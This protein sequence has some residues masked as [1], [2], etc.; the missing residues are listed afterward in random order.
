MPKKIGI[1]GKLLEL[2]L[3]VGEVEMGK[4]TGVGVGAGV[5]V[6]GGAGV[7]VGEG[8]VACATMLITALAG[9][10]AA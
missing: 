10:S 5:A 9:K 4:T 3:G 8:V 1:T 6:G 2:L 7:T